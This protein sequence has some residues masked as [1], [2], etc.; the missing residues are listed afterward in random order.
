VHTRRRLSEAISEGEAISRL[1]RVATAAEAAAAES[2]GAEGI[3]TQGTVA[4]LRN[5]TALPILVSGATAEEASAEGADA[6]LLVAE[7]EE[8]D[9]EP[10]HSRAR[11]LGLECVVD[12][13]DE[14]ELEAVLERIDPEIVLLSPRAAEDEEALDR[15]L[16]LLPD[17]P[18]GKL[19]L[20][21]LP[22]ATEEELQVLERAGVD[23]VLV[24][25]GA[26]LVAD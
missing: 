20:A 22:S 2:S 25:A 18:A 6:W 3:A 26:L 19:V 21:D 8:E 13:H 4:D 16:E 7:T 11:E 9:L 5:S 15:V 12:V 17:V 24:P 10:R 14:E 23:A 1:V